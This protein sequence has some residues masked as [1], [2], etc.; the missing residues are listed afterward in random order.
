M[1]IILSRVNN[2]DIKQ[3]KVWN[4]CFIVCHQHQTRSRKIKANKTQQ[5]SVK[6]QGLFCENWTTKYLTT[7]PSKSCF[8]IFLLI[9]FSEII[10]TLKNQWN[11]NFPNMKLITYSRLTRHQAKIH[12]SHLWRYNSWRHRGCNNFQLFHL[13]KITR[14]YY[15]L[16]TC[17]HLISLI[18]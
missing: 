9:N 11:S 18:I 13:G 16:V 4:I 10:N 8:I 17:Y 5:I 3:N 1:N 14:S 6:T 7:T 2:F 15:T 12:T